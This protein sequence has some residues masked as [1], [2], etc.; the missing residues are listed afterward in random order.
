MKGIYVLIISI[1]RGGAT[2]PIQKIGSLGK[3]EFSPGKYIYVGSAQNGIEKRIRRHLRREKR[4]FWHIDYLLDN[5]LVKV[6][7]VLYKEV[8][9]E[10]ECKTASLLL[11]YGIPVPG[12]GCSDCKCKSHLFRLK[13]HKIPQIITR[14]TTE[15]LTHS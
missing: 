10:E 2:P 5:P 14:N 3:F 15:F 12:F 9:K 11:K 6:D 4:K 7:K 8:G 13:E 1:C